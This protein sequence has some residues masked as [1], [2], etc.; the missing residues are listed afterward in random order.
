[1]KREPILPI[2]DFDPE[3]DMPRLP[4]GWGGLMMWIAIVVAV[5]AVLTVL[6]HLSS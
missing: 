2:K 1:M 6:V 5:L 4:M 3:W